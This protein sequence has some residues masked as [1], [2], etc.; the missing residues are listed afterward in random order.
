MQ[1]GDNLVTC[2][3]ILHFET[4]IWTVHCHGVPW[5]FNANIVIQ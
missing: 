3:T 1:T 2:E 4:K 5:F